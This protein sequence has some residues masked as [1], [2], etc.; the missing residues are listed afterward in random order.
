MLAPA[1]EP[2]REVAWA[3]AAPWTTLSALLRPPLPQDGC[4]KGAPRAIK[5]P[6]CWRVDLRAQ[7]W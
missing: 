3:L 5:L 1:V 6:G 2:P 7:L 4:H